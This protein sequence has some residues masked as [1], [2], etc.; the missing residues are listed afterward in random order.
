MG[1]LL[2]PAIATASKTVFSVLC[3]TIFF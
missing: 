1:T 2:E 3:W